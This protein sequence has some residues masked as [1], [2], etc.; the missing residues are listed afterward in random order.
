MVQETKRSQL[1]VKSWAPARR[2]SAHSAKAVTGCEWPD[3]NG[4]LESLKVAVSVC[5]STQNKVHHDA[6]NVYIYIYTSL[7]LSLSR[8]LSLLVYVY[9][10]EELLGANLCCLKSVSLG[11]QAIQNPSHRWVDGIQQLHIMTWRPP[12]HQSVLDRWNLWN[13]TC[14]HDSMIHDVST[15][16][17]SSIY[18]NPDFNRWQSIFFQLEDMEMLPDPVTECSCCCGSWWPKTHHAVPG[19][20]AGWLGWSDPKSPGLKSWTD[21]RWM[22]W[23]RIKLNDMIMIYLIDFKMMLNG[24]FRIARVPQCRLPQGY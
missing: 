4:S 5:F 6:F 3:T 19:L 18:R 8:S 15:I 20:G 16:F 22:I 1:S 13:L 23:Y 9:I 24:S 7:S 21:I 14:I 10:S 2:P 12:L 11:S 17:A